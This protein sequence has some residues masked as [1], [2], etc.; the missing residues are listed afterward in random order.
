M[1]DLL[2]VMTTSTNDAP[3]VV[4][5]L[6]RGTYKEDL[7]ASQHRRIMDIMTDEMVQDWNDA[8]HPGDQGESEEEYRLRLEA[9]PFEELVKVWTRGPDRCFAE[10]RNFPC[11]DMLH[12]YA[13]E[14]ESCVTSFSIVREP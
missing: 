13:M 3:H 12:Q 2:L 4:R 11:S 7:V 1:S 14:D 6:D 5:V 9:L 10:I 8:H